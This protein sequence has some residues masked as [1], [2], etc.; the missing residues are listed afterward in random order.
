MKKMSIKRNDPRPK[1]VEEWTTK[2]WEA[3]YNVK[4][5]QFETL[6]KELKGIF[7]HMHRALGKIQEIIS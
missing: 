1:P 3:A 4:N 5:A 6:K 7:I 2:E